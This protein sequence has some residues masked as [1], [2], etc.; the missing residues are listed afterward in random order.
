[1]QIIIVQAEIEQAITAHILSQV[2]VREGMRIDIDLSATRGPEGFR[3]TINIVPEN[4]PAT[5]QTDRQASELVREPASEPAKEPEAPAPA[6]V[7][8]SPRVVKATETPAKAPTPEPEA[9]E[10]KPTPE[11]D[12]VEPAAELAEAAQPQPEAE[13]QVE[14]EATITGEEGQG[15]TASDAQAS[16]TAP[17]T[18]AGKSL[19]GGLKRP[20]NA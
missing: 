17:T 13:V 18:G 19:F 12:P 20:E 2:Q 9:V 10:D 8:R 3:A 1:M 14:A 4:S 7:T 15:G 11:K 5:G 16:E 6:K